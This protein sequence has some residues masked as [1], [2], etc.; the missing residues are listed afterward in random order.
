LASF[1]LFELIL[2]VCLLIY[3]LQVFRLCH[4][5]NEDARKPYPAN[6]LTRPWITLIVPVKYNASAC[7]LC[8]Q[9]IAQQGYPQNKMEV[10]VV[11]DQ[12]DFDVAS[13]VKTVASSYPRLNISC[14]SNHGS[15]KK[16]AILSGL[17]S[18]SGTHVVLTDADCT[19]PTSWLETLLLPF[20]N[21]DCHLVLGPVQ[22]EG[23]KWMGIWDE[24]D[25]NG[26]ML[27][28]MASALLHKPVLASSCNLA[29][30]KKSFE[31]ATPFFDNLHLVGGDDM[32]I[33]MAFE[34][35]FG[36]QSIHALVKRQAL[37]KTEGVSSF[38]SFLHARIRWAAKTKYYLFSPSGLLAIGIGCLHLFLFAG[39]LFGLV[40]PAYLLP[41]IICILG[42]TAADSLLFFTG[43]KILGTFH[44]PLLMPLL[45]V[46]QVLSVP[47][48]VV[49]SAF[50]SVHQ[51]KT[52]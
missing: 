12:A 16:Q 19:H 21:D 41:V 32:F 36:G 47:L 26:M 49:M 9:S 3:C 35:K 42:K 25:Y 2:P 31:Q 34:K 52:R 1:F 17:A 23:K 7:S 46:L 43:K 13:L 22:R 37:V 40:Y 10:L 5:L 38:S 24:A 29:F 48:L 18:A 6:A 8:L 4:A 28:G 20:L 33:L 30:R 15:G 27:W 11:N 50:A 39:L 45:Q 44:R 51:W 14:I